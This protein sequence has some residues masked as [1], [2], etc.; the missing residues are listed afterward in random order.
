[1]RRDAEC[2]RAL[3]LVW[4]LSWMS[5]IVCHYPPGRPRLTRCRSPEKETFTCWWETG[6]SGRLPTS[7]H[8]YYR[9][10]SSAEVFE[11]PDYHSAGNNSCY[12]DKRHTLI[13]IIYNITV[14]ASNAL[15]KTYSDSVEV[16]V[17][18]IVQPHPPEN[19]TVSLI[20]AENNVY[21][22]VRWEP[23][24][25]ADTRSGWVTIKYEIRIKLENSTENSNSWESYSAGKQ[26][27]F[28]IYSPQP[29][30]SYL[31]QVRCKLDQGQWSEWSSFA[32]IQIPDRTS[33]NAVMIFSVTLTAFIFSL[34][35]GVL[36][37][38]MKHVKR[39]LL[40]PVPQPKIKGLDIKLL[41][42]GKSEEIFSGLLIQEYP[43][44]AQNLER[45]V[46]FFV[47]SN[48]DEEF[49][50]QAHLEY[51]TDPARKLPRNCKQT[52]QNSSEEVNSTRLM[53]PG[54]G[55]DHQDCTVKDSLILSGHGET[56]PQL[57][58]DCSG[59]L[60]KAQEQ[61]TANT[62]SEGETDSRVSITP[63]ELTGYVEVDKEKQDQE[64]YSKISDI[65]SDNI[66]VLH[67]DA[68]PIQRPKEG[69]CDQ[70][71]RET[72]ETRGDVEP[73]EYLETVTFE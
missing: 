12:F 71:K 21:I 68:A 22:L 18:D 7:H 50:G 3:T 43:Q 27:E 45:Q 36:A 26:L 23:P 42:N 65:I 1:M 2:V 32:F 56:Q 59:L 46:E 6:S 4:L 14:V 29:G 53:C 33:D 48:G 63:A 19:V 15:G 54:P 57:Y 72:E 38:K 17:M 20:Q 61:N 49:D 44:I 39:F 31:I 62:P 70:I 5:Y 10:E 51:K 64:D 24:R 25:D 67:K 69:K 28:S 41:K 40:P 13:W 30:A 9:K 37:A 11:C 52:I 34:T 8:L 60:I 73:L 58:H 16:D 35:A 66:L 47:I 55:C